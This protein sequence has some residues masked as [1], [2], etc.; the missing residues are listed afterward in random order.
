M[1]EDSVHVSRMR[2]HGGSYGHGEVY[3][4]LSPNIDLSN[5]QTLGCLAP[6]FVLQV[7]ALFPNTYWE[8]TIKYGPPLGWLSHFMFTNI[9]KVF[10]IG[11]GDNLARNN[12]LRLL[13]LDYM[14]VS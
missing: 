13:Q 6:C 5:E 4:K 9:F 8:V 1:K 3:N 14:V 10:D 2:W 7:M 11:L 12:S